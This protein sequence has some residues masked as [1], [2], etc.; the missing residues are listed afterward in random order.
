MWIYV[1]CMLSKLLVNGISGNF[2]RIVKLL[3]NVPKSCVLINNLETDYFEVQCGVKQEDITSPTI[4]SL[5]INELINE[6]NSL[7]LEV[8][9]DEENICVLLYAEDIVIFSDTE[10]NLKTLLNTVHKWCSQ[11]RLK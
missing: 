2:Y 7:N 10:A 1:E 3:Y 9:I 5:Y 11:W 6:L 8:P 4:F